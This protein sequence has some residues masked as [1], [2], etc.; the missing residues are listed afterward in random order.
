M[1][2]F[3]TGGSG[4][5][6]GAL[7]AR[8]LDDGVEVRALVRSPPAADRMAEA[9]AIPVH[10]DVFAAGTMR[11][12][13]D[14]C[15]VVFHVAGVNDACP[16]DAAPMYRVN[17]DGTRIVVAAAAAA[18]VPRVVFT[19]SAAAIGEPPGVLADEGTPHSGVFLS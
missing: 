19:S 2:V 11:E 14:G 5:L 13:L 6:G 16:R 15:A 4:F 8:L 3:V 7:I 9:G 18:G 12:A 10:G 17:V 1:A